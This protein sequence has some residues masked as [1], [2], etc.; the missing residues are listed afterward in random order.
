MGQRLAR[1]GGVGGSLAGR[2]EVRQLISGLEVLLLG[3]VGNGTCREARGQSPTECGSILGGLH[4]AGDRVVG[5]LGIWGDGVSLSGS[6]D[7][8]GIVWSSETLRDDC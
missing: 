7:D 4:T 5:T 8:G 3:L 6:H 2:G 1:G